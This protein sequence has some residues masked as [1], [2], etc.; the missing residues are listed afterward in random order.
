MDLA[1]GEAPPVQAQARLALQ[2]PAPARRSAQ[3]AV[4]DR[5]ARGL[6]RAAAGAQERR[7]TPLLN[8]LLCLAHRSPP[9]KQRPCDACVHPRRAHAHK[10]CVMSEESLCVAAPTERR[11]WASALARAP[12]WPAR[13]TPGRPGQRPAG[14]AR[15]RQRAAAVRPPAARARRCQTRSEGRAAVHHGLALL[16]SGSRSKDHGAAKHTLAPC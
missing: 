2:R 15:R 11:V 14:P 6:R 13:R 9:H 5:R 8:D 3:G 4:P 12:R 16:Q 1:L 10:A 7:P